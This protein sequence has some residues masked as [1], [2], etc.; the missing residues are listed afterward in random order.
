MRSESVFLQPKNKIIIIQPLHDMFDDVF[1]AVF[2]RHFC[3]TFHTLTSHLLPFG[4]TCPFLK[5]T[6]KCAS[7]SCTV[8][9]VVIDFGAFLC[10]LQAE[11]VF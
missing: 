1:I 3:F 5:V 2:K 10:F 4:I 7:L 9:C 11:N 8:S 6:T